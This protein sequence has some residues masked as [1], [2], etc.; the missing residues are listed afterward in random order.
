MIQLMPGKTLLIFLLF[1]WV[2]HPANAQEKVKKSS[3]DT[4]VIYET[5]I[6]YDTLFIYDTIRISGP[7]RNPVLQSMKDS[8]S[9]QGIIA[10]PSDT[11]MIFDTTVPQNLKEYL[12][13]TL[14]PYK[15]IT[16]VPLT[17]LCNKY[18]PHSEKFSCGLTA[19]NFKSSI[20]YTKSKMK[21]MKRERYHSF[22][23]GQ[24]AWGISAGGGAWHAQSFNG[25]LRSDHL[26][27]PSLGLYYE[28]MISR[29]FSFKVE[30]NYL[31]T[32]NRGIHFQQDNFMDAVQ[33][34]STAGITYADIFSWDVN[35]KADGDFHFS[36]LSVPLK[37]GYNISFVRPYVGLE[38][39]HRLKNSQLPNGNHVSALAGLNVHLLKRLSIE[40]TYSLGLSN[41]L[42][43][44]GQVQGTTAGN[45]TVLSDSRVV[46]SS[47]PA[48]DHVNNNTGSLSGRFFGISLCYSFSRN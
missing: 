44:N 27:S 6:V 5:Q 29:H 47:Y 10:D 4:I 32:A 16:A 31:W 33:S 39:M 13:D 15:P 17:S 14:Q 19:T 46:I 7:D 37:I 24:S 36:R 2:A 42:D 41:E 43:R 11:L 35:G 3:S 20:M 12:P 30:L 9:V 26:F 18:Y 8:N 45:I 1:I 22:N 38:Y 21:L 25:N 23:A 34:S 48:E 28:K 40:A